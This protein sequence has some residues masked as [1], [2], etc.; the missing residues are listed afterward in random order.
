V[1][2]SII[3]ALVAVLALS[4]CGGGSEPPAADTSTD[5]DTVEE[6][7]LPSGLV[8]SD[9]PNAMKW[10]H[11]RLDACG[12][13][14]PQDEA[15]DA[16]AVWGCVDDGA[17]DA[18]G[19]WFGAIDSDD[20]YYVNCVEDMRYLAAEALADENVEGGDLRAYREE[21]EMTLPSGMTLRDYSV[22]VFEPEP[23]EWVR[24]QRKTCAASRVVSSVENCMNEG[25]IKVCALGNW[26]GGIDPENPKYTAC[27]EDM[28]YLA[29]KKV[30][31]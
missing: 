27:V 4:A 1:G 2:R 7:K 11:E 19:N 29:E 9:Y 20:A 17:V 26:F 8:L 10:L 12:A 25:A 24:R 30:G 6:I 13:D 14:E 22:T 21:V 3:V 23:M 18:C 28:R 5:T 16:D 31:G 15:A